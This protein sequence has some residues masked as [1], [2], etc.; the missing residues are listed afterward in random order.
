MENEKATEE[1][2][3]FKN[4]A[5]ARSDQKDK[6]G[7]YS[8]EL[9]NADK[10]ISKT[11]TVKKG[12]KIKASVFATHDPAIAETDPTKAIAEAKKDVLLSLGGVV[13]GSINTNPTQQEIE[14]PLNP[15]ITPART[16][17]IQPPLL[18]LGCRK[19]NKKNGCRL[20]QAK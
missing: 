14:I 9:T 11:I 6:E 16:E 15:E 10:A 17:T 8:A 7:H 12:D 4:V 5:A 18:H 1:E 19:K 20:S 2:A 13:A 3:E